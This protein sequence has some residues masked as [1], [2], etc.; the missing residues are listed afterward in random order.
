MT[1]QTLLADAPLVQRVGLTLAHTVWQGLAAAALLRVA[2]AAVRNSAQARYALACTAMAAV[3]VAAVVTFVRV[4]ETAATASIGHSAVMTAPPSP[5]TVSVAVPTQTPEHGFDRQSAT[6]LIVLAWAA[7]VAVQAALHLLGWTR[8][9]RLGREPALGDARWW[10]ALRSMAD[11]VGVRG[12]VRLLGS[13][14]IDVPVVLGVIRP[15][16]VVPLSMVS[17][18]SVEHVEALLAHE[19]AHV[20]RHDYL[21][22]L[23]QC[24]IE[25]VLFYHPAVWWMSAQVRR[26]REHC[27]DDT[28]AD[29]IGSRSTVASALV[30]LD[31]RRGPRLALAATG[32]PLLGRVRRLTSAVPPRRRS[33][34]VT[35][36]FVATVLIIG[37]L[38]GDGPR[39]GARAQTAPSTRPAAERSAGE[40]YVGG[41]VRRQGVYAIW[42]DKRTVRQLVV[43]AGLP[44]AK[45][46]WVTVS[47]HDGDRMAKVVDGVPFA[48][49][50]KEMP[51]DIRLATGDVVRITTVEP[52]HA[53]TRPA[54]QP[55]GEV[56]IGGEVPRTGVYMLNAD[57]PMTIS[58]AVMSAGDV[59]VEHGQHAWIEVYR[60]AGARREALLSNIPYDAILDGSFPDLK[61]EP[62]DVVMVFA[63]DP[64]TREPGEPTPA[65]KLWREKYE[66]RITRDADG[67][68]TNV[69]ALEAEWRREVDAG[70]LAT[71]PTTRAAAEPVPV[72][73]DSPSLAE[74]EHNDADYASASVLLDRE[75]A[76]RPNDPKLQADQKRVQD[77][78]ECN[79]IALSN[80]RR[81]LRAA[82][83]AT[84]PATAAADERRFVI[85]GDVK[86]PASFVL[87]SERM[88][89]GNTIR[90]LAHGTV[91]G[92]DRR[93][94]LIR[95]KG[96][97]R[98]VM[99]F[100]SFNALVCNPK[101]DTLLQPDDLLLVSKDP[102]P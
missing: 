63:T 45:V 74:L 77:L 14:H 65:A 95:G 67:R 38:G 56:F 23:V 3:A 8:V 101:L 13:S 60:R 11:R 46:V 62:K 80:R 4:G 76:T 34:P 51:G 47:R 81:A 94:T 57:R 7:G 85:L 70:L 89:V 91:D 12:A 55:V 71:Q 83:P 28:A 100:D 87:T 49:P 27:C 99:H 82:G 33:G 1:M 64:A 32:S 54:T 66:P 78:R 37:L 42:N 73:S 69:E 35:I 5:S 58:Q 84:R 16:I 20:R 31:E 72:Q 41:D 97:G 19:L 52:T 44:D 92:A 25:A 18:L 96:A 24:G 50:W 39:Q 79:G 102:K 53:T 30:A 15:A 21:V 93:V 98:Q 2:F 61:L 22:N 48:A 75:A 9:R 68:P 10:A 40:V 59:S 17:E 36:V 90:D 29:A 26:E 86:Q 6:S 88:T 43:S